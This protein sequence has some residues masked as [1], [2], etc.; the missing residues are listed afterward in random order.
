MKKL[1]KNR[2]L[3]KSHELSKLKP[4]HVENELDTWARP[5]YFFMHQKADLKVRIV[6]EVTSTKTYLEAH[7]SRKAPSN[8]R[9]LRFILCELVSKV[10][11][12]A[13]R[14]LKR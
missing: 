11:K 1:A 7:L 6:K 2:Q 10:Y 5:K 14:L 12:I 9:K 13:K 8:L 4:S 3:Y